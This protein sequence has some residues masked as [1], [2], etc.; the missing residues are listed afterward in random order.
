MPRRLKEEKV[1]K[2]TLEQDIVLR[3]GGD[4]T[5]V[6][7][8]TAAARK[9]WFP[10][11]DRL[12]EDNLGSRPV[13]CWLFEQQEEK[14]SSIEEEAARLAALGELSLTMRLQSCVHH[15]PTF[16]NTSRGR[17]IT[18]GLMPPRGQR[19]GSARATRCACRNRVAAGMDRE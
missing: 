3:F 9:C 12:M 5:K 4:F 18:T 13:G 11:R 16:G 10:H 7:P 8:S 19:N 1:R 15:N 6:F 14:P 17:S 2:L